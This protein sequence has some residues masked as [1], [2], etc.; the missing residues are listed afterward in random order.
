MAIEPVERFYLEP[1]SEEDDSRAGVV[2]VSTKGHK[3]NCTVRFK[4]KASNN[5]A[6][7][8]LLLTDLRLAKDIQMKRL[9]INSDSRLVLR[10]VNP[11]FNSR[12]KCMVAYLK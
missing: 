1:F 5:A 4:F 11:N 12:D 8:E 7:Y 10:Q 6:K 9:L 3:L 2:L